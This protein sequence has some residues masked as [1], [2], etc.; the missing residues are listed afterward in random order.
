MSGRIKQLVKKSL[1][2]FIAAGV[3]VMLCSGF[4]MV[5]A[6]HWY[7]LWPT[8]M[9]FVFSAV[10]FPLLMIP[11]GFFA[12]AMMAT[13]KKYPL[14]ARA[15]TVLSFAWFVLLL[16]AYTTWSFS[17]VL[18]YIKEDPEVLYPAIAWAI[19][20][21]LTPWGFFATRDR[22]SVF[23][24]GLVYMATAVAVVLFPLAM[25]YAIEP[26]MVLRFYALA[27]GSMVALQA[28]YEK[29]FIKPEAV[30]A[31]AQAPEA[32]VSAPADEK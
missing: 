7:A 2:P 14:A 8:A 27:L 13:E 28:L 18:P 22:D 5:G 24:T 6:G 20:A 17:V 26:Y 25:H 16:A 3:A 23:F 11:A 32:E 4:W 9:A 12:G 10:L 30:L 1:N 15:F 29:L 31:G 19:S 21:A